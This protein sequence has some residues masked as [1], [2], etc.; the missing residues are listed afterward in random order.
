MIMMMEEEEKNKKKKGKAK[1]G[2]IH[3]LSTHL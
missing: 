3:K 2:N 1:E